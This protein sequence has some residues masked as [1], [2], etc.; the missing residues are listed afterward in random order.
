MSATA[1]TKSSKL[2]KL[3]DG[4]A[5]LVKKLTDQKPITVRFSTNE[6]TWV[7][8]NADDL[9]EIKRKLPIPSYMSD[10]HFSQHDVIVTRATG[11]GSNVYGK[12]GVATGIFHTKAPKGLPKT[13]WDNLGFGKNGFT[14]KGEDLESAPFLMLED[15]RFAKV[16]F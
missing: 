14:A 1:P 4:S 7:E 9:D 11:C 12:A 3:I 5:K 8:V 15:K 13:G 10:V 6:G 16:H 2:K